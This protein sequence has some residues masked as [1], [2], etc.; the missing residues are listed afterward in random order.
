MRVKSNVRRLYAAD[1]ETG[2]KR[3]VVPFR[4]HATPQTQTVFISVFITAAP[5]LQILSG[6]CLCFL[7]AAAAGGGIHWPESLEVHVP[8]PDAVL[9]SVSPQHSTVMRTAFAC[10]KQVIRCPLRQTYSYINKYSLR[11]WVQMY[12]VLY[13]TVQFTISAA[14]HISC[15]SPAVG[16]VENSS[17]G[18]RAL[19]VVRRVASRRAAGGEVC[20][21]RPA[22]WRWG[23]HITSERREDAPAG[24]LR[25]AQSPRGFAAAVCRSRR[26]SRE[27]E[28]STA[29]TVHSYCMYGYVMWERCGTSFTHT[30]PDAEFG[31]QQGSG[32]VTGGVPLSDASPVLG[33]NRFGSPEVSRSDL[34]WSEPSSECCR[35]SDK[36]AYNTWILY[37]QLRSRIQRFSAQRGSIDAKLA[38]G[39]NV[40][41]AG[42]RSEARTSEIYA[43]ADRPELC[44]RIRS[45][46]RAEQ[47][48]R[49]ALE[50]VTSFQTDY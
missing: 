40:H 14:P 45:F 43:K 8:Q 10:L 11:I 25:A 24:P 22:A 28:N 37:V 27:I 19:D 34:S 18:A 38:G 2:S 4:G 48:G 1:R 26:T 35:W 15:T 46:R 5:R 3:P 31:V 42:C 50:R 21:R 49:G 47:K 17:S 44:R 20:V 41:P 16:G 7:L 9:Y 12:S 39:E 33:A 36:R 32:C 13:T 23:A 30:N 29:H 6:L